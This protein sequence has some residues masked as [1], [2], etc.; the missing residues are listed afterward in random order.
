M[1]VSYVISVN[2]LF[3]QKIFLPK[4]HPSPY[5]Y[6]VVGTLPRDFRVR[7]LELMRIQHMARDGG[8]MICKMEI[9]FH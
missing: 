9:I 3:L 7:S 1:H 5:S 8:E 6:K 4:H 2:I